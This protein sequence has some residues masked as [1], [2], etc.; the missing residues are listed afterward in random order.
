[1]GDE[2]SDRGALD[3]DY[4]TSGSWRAEPRGI[5]N[6]ALDSD[7]ASFDTSSLSVDPSLNRHKNERPSTQHPPEPVDDPP[8]LEPNTFRGAVLRRNLHRI[9][10]RIKRP[11]S[12]AVDKSNLSG[13]GDKIKASLT[14]RCLRFLQ[15]G[16]QA[17][18][19]GSGLLVC[20]PLWWSVRIFNE[21]CPLYSNIA[22]S[23]SANRTLS[24][25]QGTSV[26]GGTSSCLFC[27]FTAVTAVIYAL[28]WFWFFILMTDWG[29]KTLI[30]EGPPPDLVMMIPTIAVNSM[31][32]AISFVIAG[33]TTVGIGQ[34]C[35][36]IEHSLRQGVTP[37]PSS[38]VKST[39]IP[40]SPRPCSFVGTMEWSNVEDGFLTYGYLQAAVAG[41]WLLLI[42]LGLQTAVASIRISMYYQTLAWEEESYWSDD[43]EEAAERKQMETQEDPI[44]HSDSEDV[45]GSN[46]VG[47]RRSRGMTMSHV[48]PQDPSVEMNSWDQST[49]ST[50]IM[51]QI[52]IEHPSPDIKRK[53]SD[54]DAH[55]L[56]PHSPDSKD[57]LDGLLDSYEFEDEDSDGETKPKVRHKKETKN[58]KQTPKR[59]EGT[60]DSPSDSPARGSS[61]M[62]ASSRTL[63]F[64]QEPQIHVYEM[65]ESDFEDDEDHKMSA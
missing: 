44:C 13:F 64:S 39:P 8:P 46:H 30:K 28:I 52:K 9:T 14:D 12:H 51:P 55:K 61:P 5:I 49:N 36:S 38:E 56:P 58:V 29:K 42:S 43:L 45:V 60:I 4:H 21:N 27:T 24:L 20:L 10:Q 11:I 19:M 40:T 41:S 33:M 54:P 48:L 31:L 2:I 47:S 34:W 32:F 26:W 1:M 53:S 7:S 18:I 6:E 63:S 35:S 15:I 37:T 25:D 57:T 16:L 22:V 65:S 62:L 59:K 50:P 17:G 23:V 3:L